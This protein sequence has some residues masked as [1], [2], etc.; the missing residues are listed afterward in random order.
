[1]PPTPALLGLDRA[2]LAEALS[3]AD[4]P[5]LRARQLARWLYAGETDF[6]KMSDLPADVRE[7]LGERYV[8]S[9]LVETRRVESED[10][11]VKVLA[12]GGDEESFECVLL[13]Y[14]DRVSCCLSTQVGCPMGCAFCATGLGGFDRNL[15]A[16]EILGQYFLLQSISPRRISHVVYMGM[17]EPLLNYPE[18]VKSIRLFKQEV[19]LSPRHIT[20]STVGIVPRIRELAQENL[21]IHLAISLHSTKDKIRNSLMPVNQKWPISEVLSAAKEYANATGRKVTFE[22]LLIEGVTDTIDQAEDLATM[23]RGFPS[24]VN[25]IPFNYVSTGQG[26]K[27]PAPSRITQFRRTLESSGVNVTQRRER[28]HRIAAACGQLAGVHGGRF[29]RRRSPSDLSV[30]S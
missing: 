25:L 30:L 21:P 16:G 4:R 1:M 5:A 18:V 23:V 11:V 20:V 27:R 24:L 28:G 9:G 6:E 26:F 17:G 19:G 8:A 22:Y 12:H 14:A 13:P 29:A 10:G 7:A 3:S 2:E 15:S